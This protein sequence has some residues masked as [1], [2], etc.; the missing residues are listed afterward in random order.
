[1][2][3]FML[4]LIALPLGKQ[5]AGGMRHAHT[6]AHANQQSHHPAYLIITNAT[7]EEDL[8]LGKRARRMRAKGPEEEGFEG[9]ASPP[10]MRPPRPRPGVAP[11]MPG[12]RGAMDVDGD[13]ARGDKRK[14]K[15]G[16]ACSWA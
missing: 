7:D 15:V 2:V 6:R 9:M 8:P 4:P 5:Q 14:R 13:G 10:G 3:L 11:G 16:G 12:A 1:M